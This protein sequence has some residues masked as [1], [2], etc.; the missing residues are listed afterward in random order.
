MAL[1]DRLEVHKGVVEHL[2]T[3]FTIESDLKVY[4]DAFDKLVSWVD[5]SLDMCRVSNST[6]GRM[7]GIR[8]AAPFVAS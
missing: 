7:G 3:S 6:A 5:S 8:S 1:A 4:T 2:V